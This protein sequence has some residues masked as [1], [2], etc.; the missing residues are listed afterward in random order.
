MTFG[1]PGFNLPAPVMR[2]RADGDHA[3]E[4]REG[5]RGRWYFWMDGQLLDLVT[6]PDSWQVAYRATPLDAYL[7]V[8]EPALPLVRLWC[9]FWG[10]GRWAIH[11]AGIR[12]GALELANEG[13]FYREGTWRWPWEWRRVRRDYLAGRF[14]RAPR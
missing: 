13:G 5:L 8:R 3:L 7:V 12:L 6:L 4:L 10:G 9:W 14:R 11:R 1:I 2:A